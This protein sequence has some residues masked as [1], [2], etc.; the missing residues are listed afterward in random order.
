ME[1]IK[2]ESSNISEIGYNEK[3]QICKIIFNTNSSYLYFPFPKELWMAFKK[4]KSFGKFFY[5]YIKSNPTIEVEKINS[6]SKL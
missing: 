5:K 6:S 1:M 3:K 2:V 4:A